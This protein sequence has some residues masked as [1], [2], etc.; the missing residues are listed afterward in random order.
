MVRV[1]VRAKKEADYKLLYM[2]NP[3]RGFISQ[4]ELCT[5]K[6]VTRDNVPISPSVCELAD[7]TRKGLV[8]KPVPTSTGMCGSYFMHWC[9][10]ERKLIF[11]P[12]DEGPE[13]GINRKGR[14]E[15]GTVVGEGYIREAAAYLLDRP[16]EGERG[17][18]RV[19]STCKYHLT[20]VISWNHILVLEYKSICVI[21][22]SLVIF[23]FE[24]QRTNVYLTLI[25]YVFVRFYAHYKLGKD[26]TIEWFHW[27]LTKVPF[28]HE[29]ID[30][31]NNLDAEEDLAMLKSY[32]WTMPCQNARIFRTDTMLLIVLRLL[33][34]MSLGC[35]DH[36]HTCANSGNGYKG[37]GKRKFYPTRDGIG[38]A[39]IRKEKGFM[40]NEGNQGREIIHSVLKT[41]AIG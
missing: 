14:A 8:N 25:V 15:V 24:S 38:R 29:T 5:L 18:S 13:Y 40:G 20:L 7:S 3:V 28:S 27:D 30:Y 19:H 36:S 17:A 26:F 32:G 33:V 21:G 39:G 35:V 16:R 11:K 2:K 41:F 31:I 22:I 4:E 12:P 1:F 23:D 34:R 37:E 9:L 6:L 10:G